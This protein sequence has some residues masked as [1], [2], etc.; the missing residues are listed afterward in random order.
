MNNQLIRAVLDQPEAWEAA[1]YPRQR[2]APP[3]FALDWR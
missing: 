2:Q 1:V 3:A